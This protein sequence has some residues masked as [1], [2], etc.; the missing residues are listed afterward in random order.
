M[1]VGFLV[2][3]TAPQRKRGGV[4]IASN[5]HRSFFLDR[6]RV[7]CIER[8]VLVVSCALDGGYITLFHFADVAVAVVSP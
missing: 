1:A 8:C 4:G 6:A 5:T 2:L 7:L 3:D